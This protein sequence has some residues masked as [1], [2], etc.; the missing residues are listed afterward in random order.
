MRKTAVLLTG[1]LA[2]L[3]STGAVG[4]TRAGPVILRPDE[5]KSMTMES[6]LAS[7]E[8]YLKDI[9]QMSAQVVTGLDEAKGRKDFARINCIGE[10]LTAVKGLARLTEQ[11]ATSLRE[12][13]AAKDRAGAEHEYVK[14]TIARNKVIDMHAQSRSCGGASAETVFEGA[15][16]I[17]KAF[18]ADLPR[19]NPSAGLEVPAIVVEPPPSASPYY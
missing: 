6:M 16:Q 4:E 8:A 19:E 11:N 9:R 17:E 15:P 18:D 1:L 12:R 2:T 10:V 14:I 5:L 7:G 13:V 3:V